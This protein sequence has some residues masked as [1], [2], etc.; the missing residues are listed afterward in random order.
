MRTLERLRVVMQVLLRGKIPWP[1]DPVADRLYRSPT[2]FAPVFVGS[3]RHSLLVPTTAAMV[4]VAA[5]AISGCGPDESGDGGEGS[6][7]AGE[8]ETSGSRQQAQLEDSLRAGEGPPEVMF[9]PPIDPLDCELLRQAASDVVAESA[10]TA[11][12]C[13]AELE[14]AEARAF[15][16]EATL[17]R[18]VASVCLGNPALALPDLAIAAELKEDL[19]DESRRVF[20]ALDPSNL[21][22]STTQWQVFIE[23]R[24]ELFGQTP[25]GTGLPTIS[26]S[27]SSSASASPSSSAS[28]SPS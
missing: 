5:I 2:A 19:S 12:P 16:A 8:S 20:D 24:P 22:S 17:Y 21:P 10:G 15:V 7:D 3:R 28:A 18:A 4:L 25:Q 26:D 13:P 11:T 23:E 6:G 1:P 27:P 14:D 9:A